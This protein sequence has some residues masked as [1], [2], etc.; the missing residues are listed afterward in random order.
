MIFIVDS[1]GMSDT[2]AFYENQT[3]RLKPIDAWKRWVL[4]KDCS[5]GNAPNIIFI[6]QLERDIGLRLHVVQYL[7]PGDQ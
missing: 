2:C 4:L 7:S 6:G 5:E 1:N 3:F